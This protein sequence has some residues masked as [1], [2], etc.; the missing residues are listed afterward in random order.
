MLVPLSREVGLLKRARSSLRMLAALATLALL[1]TACGG[2][3]AGGEAG[4]EEGGQGGTFVFAQASD[5]TSMDAALIS[6]GESSRVVNQIFEG[7]VGTKEGSL[8]TEPGLAES[9]EPSEDGRAWTFKLRQGVK[10]HDGTDFNAEAVCFNFDRQYN[11][12]G[13]LASD[14]L[15]Y[16]WNSFF[17][18]FADSQEKGL[19]E[20]CEA[21]DEHT[22]VIHLT[23]PSASFI[24]A[25]SQFA[26]FIQSPTALQ[27][28]KADSVSGTE[29]QP[30]FEGTY[31]LEHPTG[32]GPFRFKEF[33]ANDRVVLERNP[34]YWGEPA[35]VEQL[36]FRT[37]PDL[38]ARRQALEAGEIQGYDQVD[39]NDLQALRDAGFQVQ[40]RDPLNVA[41]IG[42]NQAKP[43]MDNIKI[44][45]AV[46]HAINKD[47]LLKA[48]YPPGA[49]PAIQ[50]MPEAIPGY[51]PD[52]STYDYDPERARQ[53]IAESGVRN[54][55]IEFW[56]PT[57]VSRPYMPDPEANFQAFTADLEKV[58]FR[59]VPK[60]APWSP[61]FLEGYQSGAYQMYLIGWNADFG[62]A[63]NFLG[64]FFQS[65]TPQFG[66]DNP[67]IFNLLNQA[68]QETDEA[69]RE[70][71]YQQANAAIMEYL[72]SVPYAHTASYVALAPNVEGF[73]TSPL[74]NEKFATVSVSQ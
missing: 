64:V 69:R 52:V 13:L 73:V 46:A 74:T 1:A 25:M 71:L 68:E 53:L 65:K 36:I 10:F 51:N 66:F 12:T 47:A 43:P 48:L 11:F 29:D 37:I 63:D 8:E 4:G 30:R 9:W 14:A 67:E 31:G 18:G 17:E 3:D 6:D 19:Y 41:Y 62:D 32:T 72:P 20:S 45:Q 54:P 49:E 5:P 26:F 15:S 50:F 35:K 23:K 21:S 42:M 38:P 58:G 60:S 28:Y 56:Y 59:I 22:A 2:G 44:R 7:L 61:D 57:D 55:T 33:R 70:Q 34:D 39:P 16:Y 27:E 24:P 40:E